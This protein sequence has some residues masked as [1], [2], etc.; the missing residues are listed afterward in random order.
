MKGRHI[1]LLLALFIAAPLHG[2]M[3]PQLRLDE[4]VITVRVPKKLRTFKPFWGFPRKDGAGETIIEKDGCFYAVQDPDDSLA[5]PAWVTWNL[6]LAEF[7]DD[8][9]KFT[10]LLPVRYADQPVLKSVLDECYRWAWRKPYGNSCVVCG[11]LYGNRDSSVPAAF[12]VSVCKKEKIEGPTSLGFSSLAWIVP[13][14]AR[15]T[16]KVYDLASTVNLVE[17][18]SGYDLYPK[19]PSAVQEQVEEISV[20][21]LF[22]PFQEIE[23]EI[24][25]EVEFEIEYEMIEIE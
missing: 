8:R 21:E 24:Q 4:A 1:I 13:V 11:P 17:Y 9:D 25:Q 23:Y 22:C 3:I 14:D 10:P 12:F 6:D 7:G 19:L 20:F 16:G 2:Q 15:I 18:R 5:V